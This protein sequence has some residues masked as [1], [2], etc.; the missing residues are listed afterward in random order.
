L[1]ILN[2]YFYNKVKVIESNVNTDDLVIMDYKIYHENYISIFTSL[3]NV[4]YLTDV[5]L[6]DIEQK[7]IETLKQGNHVYIYD[8]AAIT[9]PYVKRRYKLKGLSE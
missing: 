3:N 8:D 9:T 2:Y 5:S 4:I 7:K 1:L 6:D